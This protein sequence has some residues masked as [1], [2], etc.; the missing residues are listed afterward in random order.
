MIRVLFIFLFLVPTSAFAIECIGP[1]KAHHFLVYL[2]GMDTKTPGEQE[3]SN[4]KK[5]A[6]MAEN[7]N[8]RIAVPRAVN[9]CPK[10]KNLVCW[11]WNFNDQTVIEKALAS[12]DAAAKECFP[13]EKKLGLIGFSNG[14][15]V[16][17]QIIKDC[18]KTDFSWFVS[19]GAAGSWTQNNSKNLSH[20]GTLKLLA[21]K[22]DKWNYQPMKELE[23]NLKT[24][25]ADVELVEY[26]DGHLIPSVELEGVVKKLIQKK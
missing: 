3:Q 20:C 9:S 10:D 6:V 11:G 13:K 1:Q 14:G 12:V 7:L 4:R 17:N 5:L 21:G 26:N 18:T 25:K 24:N 22:K 23:L 2:H 8:L 19:I 16:A 15:F